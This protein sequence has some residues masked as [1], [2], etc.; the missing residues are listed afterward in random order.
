MG[1]EL[2][3]NG[4]GSV[5]PQRTCDRDYFFEELH[6]PDTD[7][8]TIIDPVYK[9]YISPLRLRR[10][11]KIMKMGAHAAMMC[12]DEAQIEVPDA[13]TVGTGMGS[14]GETENFLSQMIE[15]NEGLLSP[16]PFIQSTHNAV[17]G[18]IALMLKCSG[19]NFTFVNRGFSFESALL[20]ARLLLNEEETENILVGGVDI[21][22]EK[23]QMLTKKRDWWKQAN[24]V[25]VELLKSKTQAAYAGEG[26]VFFLLGKKQNTNAYARVLGLKTIFNL[27]E[28]GVTKPELE[29]FLGESKLSIEDIDVLVLGVNGD[30][31]KDQAYHDV[32]ALFQNKSHVYFKHFCGEYHTSNSFA[33]LLS[34]AIIKKQKIPELALMNGKQPNEIRN[35]LIYNHWNGVYHSLTL[36]SQC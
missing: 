25:D 17:G 5:T 3:I 27:N 20:D 23:V 32:A 26:A 35:V 33:M 14:L 10:M 2:F 30:N 12:L 9:E 29:Q 6:Q 1:M 11:G 15:S 8:Y 19:H 28:E 21:L 24:T 36:L 22:T 13:I 34:A 18:K 7:F 31:I 4:T 16:T